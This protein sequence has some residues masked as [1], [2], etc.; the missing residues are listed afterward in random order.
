[1]NAK[2]KIR[3]TEGDIFKR[4]EE[5]EDKAKINLLWLRI[6]YNKILVHNVVTRPVAYVMKI[7]TR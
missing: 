2:G 4:D 3:H 5:Q 7:A 6:L 1:M